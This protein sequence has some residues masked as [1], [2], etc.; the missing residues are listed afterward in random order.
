MLA[1]LKADF[2]F[3]KS[4]IFNFAWSLAPPDWFKFKMKPKQKSNEQKM[5]FHWFKRKGT[6]ILHQGCVSYNRI[7]C[8]RGIQVVLS[9]FKP[10]QLDTK[11]LP[12]AQGHNPSHNDRRCHQNRW[13][14]QDRAVIFRIMTG[15][16][17]RKPD[18]LWS[19]LAKDWSPPAGWI[20][21]DENWQWEDPRPYRWRPLSR[22]GSSRISD[23]QPRLEVDHLG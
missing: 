9:T 14:H 17:I 7:I 12:P 19:K 1:L 22:S 18:C 3:K 5:N 16:A 21:F 2:C 8:S 15:F 6:L 23:Y 4:P 11:G 13:C 10:N 20:F